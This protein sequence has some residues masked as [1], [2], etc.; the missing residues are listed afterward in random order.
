VR[1]KNWCLAA[2]A[3]ENVSMTFP[4]QRALDDV[5]LQADGGDVRLRSL[6][7]VPQRHAVF[8]TLD[9]RH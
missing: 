5:S 2:V 9:P 1:S 4:S 6:G 3:A 8:A 7:D